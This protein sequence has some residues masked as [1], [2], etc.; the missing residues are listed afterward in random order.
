MARNEDIDLRK[1]EI[2]KATEENGGYKYLRISNFTLKSAGIKEL[3]NQK[4]DAC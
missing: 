3:I 4:Q 2:M 1:E